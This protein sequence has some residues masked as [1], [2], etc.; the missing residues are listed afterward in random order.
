M[1]HAR[2]THIADLLETG[3][4]LPPASAQ[5]LREC[6]RRWSFGL[7]LND[8]FQLTAGDARRERDSLL[9]ENLDALPATA[10]TAR[11]R[12][13]AS[14]IRRIHSGRQTDYPWLRRADSLCR[15]PETP[16]QL[17]NILR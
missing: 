9:R 12:I 15:L 8:A 1:S 10:P 14:E 4:G 6:L 13:L 17:F 16:R 7:P 5:W 2:L 3:D 11:A